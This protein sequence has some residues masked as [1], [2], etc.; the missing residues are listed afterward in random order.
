MGLTLAVGAG[1]ALNEF[2]R[3]AEP[4][5]QALWLAGAWISAVL[6][7]LF[8]FLSGIPDQPKEKQEDDNA[9]TEP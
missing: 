5:I 7:A 9:R 8:V 2:I 4:M 1:Y 6:A 3:A